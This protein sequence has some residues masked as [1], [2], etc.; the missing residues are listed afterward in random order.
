MSTEHSIWLTERE[1]IIQGIGGAAQ[2]RG[3]DS[4][5]LRFTSLGADSFAYRQCDVDAWLATENA[6]INP[7]TG[8]A[9]PS[10]ATAPARQS[11][12]MP[13]QTIRPLYAPA[14][15]VHVGGARAA[16]QSAIDSRV[17]GGMSKADAIRAVDQADPDLRLKM[18]AEH[19]QRN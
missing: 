13:S 6:T 1:L 10:P 11:A 5:K 7:R 8:R 17:D 3:R 9:E 16:W 19:N 14:Q 2:R 12:P 18:L 15:A 4:G